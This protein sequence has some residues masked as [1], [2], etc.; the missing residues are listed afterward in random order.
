MI[1]NARITGTKLGYEDHGI[2]TFWLSLDYGGSGQGFGG[3]ALDSYD[4]EKDCRKH[5]KYAGVC[6]E[7]ILKVVGVD[8]WEDMKGKYV[9]ADIDGEASL[10]DLIKGIIHI[11]DDDISFYPKE[12]WEAIKNDPQ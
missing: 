6:I 11:L 10:G 2:L 9:R 8:N 5:S 4:K 12:T 3:Y 1:I 7:K